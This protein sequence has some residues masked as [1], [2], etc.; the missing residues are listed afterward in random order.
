M[1]SW[2]W[3]ALPITRFYFW[4]FYGL[5]IEGRAHIPRRGGF[6][7]ASNHA[8][9]LDPPALGAAVGVRDL[10]FMARSSLFANPIF[11]WLIRKV[12]AHPVER[13]KGLDQDW[14]SFLR[15][16]ERGQ[17]LLV[18]P[19]GTRTLTGELQRGKLGFGKLAYAARVPIIPVYLHGTFAAFP[20]GGK[21]RF[22]RLSAR[23]GPPV[24]VDDLRAGPDEAKTWRAISERT[25]EAIATLKTKAT[26]EG[27]EK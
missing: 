23:F 11:G 4:L 3:L 12:N 9:Y 19:E 14:G 27:T 21:H 17:G 25:V 10:H 8:S 18:F 6:L 26:T 24:P 22:L 7:L 13:G 20:K 15:L 2:Y 16:L 1:S 5:R